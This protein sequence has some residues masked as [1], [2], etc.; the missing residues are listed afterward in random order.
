MFLARLEEHLPR[1]VDGLV[2]L[3]ERK[4]LEVELPD[5]LAEVRVAWWQ[6]RLLEGRT[7]LL[8]Q[9]EVGRAVTVEG[10]EVLSA[11]FLELDDL[12][13]VFLEDAHGLVRQ[14]LELRERHP[15]ELEVPARPLVRLGVGERDRVEGDESVEEAANDGKGGA[16]NQLLMPSW[17]KPLAHGLEADLLGGK[18]QRK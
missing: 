6:V 15:G 5:R 12:L 1:L 13:T 14:G 17:R 7:G 9:C 18:R 8:Q 3:V 4:P 10:V 11:D 2:L 16:A